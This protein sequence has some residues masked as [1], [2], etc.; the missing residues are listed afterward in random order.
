MLKK[1]PSS[2]VTTAAA[3]FEAKIY[4]KRFQTSSHIKTCSARLF[5]SSPFCHSSASQSGVREIHICSRENW[6][7]RAI[8][9]REERSLFI[10]YIANTARKT[11]RYKSQ[12]I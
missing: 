9:S 3:H 11:D 2:S 7:L 6:T 12:P 8:D 10:A 4:F 1:V 5:F